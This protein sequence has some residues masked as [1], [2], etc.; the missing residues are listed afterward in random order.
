MLASI[1]T[2]ERE[3]HSRN[4]DD[5]KEISKRMDPAVPDEKRANLNNRASNTPSRRTGNAS[6]IRL[7]TM[8]LGIDWKNPDSNDPC[9]Q[10]KKKKKRVI[11][12]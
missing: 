6:P 9:P 11:G 4:T 12:Y 10:K 5:D 1:Y 7:Y 2:A 8:I 3:I